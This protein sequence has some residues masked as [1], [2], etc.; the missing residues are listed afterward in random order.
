MTILTALLVHGH[1]SSDEVQ[2]L[3]VFGQ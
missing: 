1:K 2:K 3:P